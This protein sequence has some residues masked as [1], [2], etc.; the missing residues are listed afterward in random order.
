[1][2]AGRRSYRRAS[3]YEPALASRSR[4]M[5]RQAALGYTQSSR[6]TQQMPDIGSAQRRETQKSN[7]RA[8]LDDPRL[9]EVTGVLSRKMS[10]WDKKEIPADEVALLQLA[11]EFQDLRDRRPK[12]TRS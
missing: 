6:S 10:A 12:P 3:N 9:Q 7:S 2:E 1:M 11:I 8:I 5:S 4:E